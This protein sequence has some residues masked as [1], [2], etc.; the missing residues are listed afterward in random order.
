MFLAGDADEP[1]QTC[2]CNPIADGEGDGSKTILALTP[3]SDSGEKM[4][5][6]KRER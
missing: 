3:E 6:R 2:V 1:N 5:E 4:R